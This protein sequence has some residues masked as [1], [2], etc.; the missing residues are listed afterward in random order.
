[1][2]EVD[3]LR[4]LIPHWIEHNDEHANEF[5]SW[6]DK[7]TQVTP[8]LLAAVEATQEVNRA[9]AIALE[10]LGGALPHPHHHSNN[11]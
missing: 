9:L 7:V 5:R 2:N 10:T 6:A 4:V 1:M 3:K 11:H 8:D